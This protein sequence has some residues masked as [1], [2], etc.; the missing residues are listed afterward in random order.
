M[1]GASLG[2]KIPVFFWQAAEHGRWHDSLDLNCRG[3]SFFPFRFS[4][5]LCVDTQGCLPYLKNNSR[6]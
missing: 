6:D 1:V 4:L 5:S 2:H 3:I